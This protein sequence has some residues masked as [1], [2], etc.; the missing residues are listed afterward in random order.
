MAGDQTWGAQLV[1]ADFV[2]SQQ[3]GSVAGTA[4]LARRP[5]PG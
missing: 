2:A 1:A 5:H 3:R 4:P